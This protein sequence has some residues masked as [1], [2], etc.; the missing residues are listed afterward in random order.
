MR[1]KEKIMRRIESWR[2]MRDK[3]NE[4]NKNAMRW[5]MMYEAREVRTVAEDTTSTRATRR[6]GQQQTPPVRL[7]HCT[8]CSR[9]V[10]FPS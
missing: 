5:T 10:L 8:N 6:R 4:D 7:G 3:Y 2:M 9:L 1:D